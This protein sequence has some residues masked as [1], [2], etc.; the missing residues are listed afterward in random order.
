MSSKLFW[1]LKHI[2]TIVCSVCS[3]RE[4]D[5][6]HNVPWTMR[7]PVQR[8]DDTDIFDEIGP[9]GSAFKNPLIKKVIIRGTFK[10]FDEKG[11][12]AVS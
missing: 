4:N 2:V 1:N 5:K 8:S 11:T 3:L 12:L 6:G 9:G 10:R 7:S